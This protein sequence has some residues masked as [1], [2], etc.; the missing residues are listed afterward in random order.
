MDKVCAFCDK[1][2]GMCYTSNPPKRK[3]TITGKF[4]EYDHICDVR[5]N[6]DRIRAMS[7]EE[8]A[9]YLAEIGNDVSNGIEYS[10]R[11]DDWLEWLKQPVKIEKVEEIPDGWY[12]CQYCGKVFKPTIKRPQKFC[13]TVCR[14]KSYSPNRKGQK[15]EYMREYRARKR[16]EVNGQT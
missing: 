5:T 7:D 4:H 2:D 9:E 6:A 11:P 15:A 3:C 8:L 12:K 16:A 14:E 10:E 13:D 1:T